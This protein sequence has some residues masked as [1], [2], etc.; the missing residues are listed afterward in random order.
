M[1]WS[2]KHEQSSSICGADGEQESNP[3]R[4]YAGTTSSP[5]SPHSD[6]KSTPNDQHDTPNVFTDAENDNE[7]LNNGP[8]DANPHER[9]GKSDDTIDKDLDLFFLDQAEAPVRATRDHYPSQSSNV[10]SATDLEVLWM[11]GEQNTCDFGFDWVPQNYHMAMKPSTSHNDSS[12]DS[13]HSSALGIDIIRRSRSP[14]LSTSCQ[15]SAPLMTGLFDLQGKLIEAYFTTVCRIFSVFD[16]PQNLFRS[17][18]CRKWQNS[19]AMFYAMLSMAS[20]KLGRQ[21][22]TYKK[23]ASEYQSLAIKH[24][25]ETLNMASS[26]TPELLFVVLMLGLSTAWHDVSDL[27]LIH[28]QALQKAVLNSAIT[29]SEDELETFDFFKKALIYWEMVISSVSEDITVHDYNGLTP[30]RSV[31]IPE[32]NPFSMERLKP[33]PWG[34]IAQ[35][36]QA[37]F[38]R[39]VRLFRQLRSFEHGSKTPKSGITDPAVFLQAVEALE[40]EI[41]KLELPNLHEIANTGDENTPPIH[42]L[43]LAEAYM[44]ANLYQL[45]QVFPNLLSKRGRHLN[46][47]HGSRSQMQNLTMLSSSLPHSAATS[48][49]WLKFLGRNIIIRLDQIHISSGTSCVQPLLLLVGSTSLSINPDSKYSE[50]EAEILRIRESVLARMSSISL[51]CLSEPIHAVELAVKEIFKR[52]DVGVKVFWMDMLQNMGLS[53]IIG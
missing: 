35:E 5:E 30:C 27:G 12:N 43:L 33:H 7:L 49:D 31:A 24:L 39:L 25:S 44:F 45:Y 37:L 23:Y 34:S 9:P 29:Y 22:L 3:G 20:A 28:L 16:S 6:S 42:H 11:V 36:P 50:E 21:S 15:S 10:I 13:P 32:S 52:L 46:H 17:Y 14:T 40:D 48:E 38:T 18:V 8:D 19:S 4:G 51:A 2:R 53:T 41:W 1:R 47:K 26:W